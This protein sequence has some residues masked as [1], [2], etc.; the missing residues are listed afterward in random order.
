MNIRQ[1]IQKFK[2]A[3]TVQ[4]D[5]GGFVWQKKDPDIDTSKLNPTLTRFIS[6]LPKELQNEVLVTDTYH[7]HEH[8]KKSRHYDNNAIDLRFSDNIYK[9]S[10]TPEGQSWRKQNNITLLDP[11]HGTGKHL[12]FSYGTG[13]ENLN[14]VSGIYKSNQEYSNTPVTQTQT[15]TQ[16]YTPT[17][18]PTIPGIEGIDLTKSSIEEIK[19][20][21]SITQQRL[22]QEQ[23]EREQLLNLIPQAGLDKSYQKGGSIEK[24][25]WISNKIVLLIKENYP[26]DQAVAIAYSMYK[27]QHK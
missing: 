7:S 24:K 5:P 26:K 3:G 2:E 14:D 6:G 18:A 21:K 15:Q 4:N 10:L 27:Q 16:W 20:E 22:E 19:P 13:S 11:N 9:W 17:Q 12:H 23:I 25:N 8:K 1:Y